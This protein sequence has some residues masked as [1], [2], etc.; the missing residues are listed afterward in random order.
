MAELEQALEAADCKFL[1]TPENAVVDAA[2]TVRGAGGKGSPAVV[3]AIGTIISSLNAMLVGPADR[4]NVLPNIELHT[5]VQH[6]ATRDPGVLDIRCDCVACA[7]GEACTD[8]IRRLFNHTNNYHLQNYTWENITPVPLM[9]SQT[10]MTD[11]ERCRIFRKT[12]PLMEKISRR[13][14]LPSCFYD[15]TAYKFVGHLPPEARERGP[16]FGRVAMVGNGI[17][18]DT[19]C[20]F[21]RGHVE[22]FD[23]RFNG[24]GFRDVDFAQFDTIVSDAAQVS[25]SGD[26]MGEWPELITFLKSAVRAGLR[27]IYK[28]TYVEAFSPVVRKPRGANLEVVCDSGWDRDGH[29]VITYDEVVEKIVGSNNFRNLVQSG[30]TPVGNTFVD[31]DAMDELCR[32]E[33]EI[34]PLVRQVNAALEYTRPRLT[35]K[36]DKHANSTPFQ[37]EKFTNFLF[38]PMTARARTIPTSVSRVLKALSQL[39]GGEIE[40]PDFFPR[41]SDLQGLLP[42]RLYYLQLVVRNTCRSMG[43]AEAA[44]LV[45][46]VSIMLENGQIPDEPNSYDLDALLSVDL[47]DLDSLGGDSYGREDDGEN[48]EDDW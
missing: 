41:E 48:F 27:V 22:Y 4:W 28:C 39:P 29:G 15:S 7:R 20:F 37:D 25:G 2:R 43:A 17:V 33:A 24:R 18:G 26:G 3:A 1:L 36:H 23:P 12:N 45:R 19:S 32:A 46:Q 10:I 44:A 11:L 9:K 30:E 16:G 34:Q 42:P 31:L 47:G 8:Y 5:F 21:L 40:A 35:V 13:N 14:D 6:L 38:R